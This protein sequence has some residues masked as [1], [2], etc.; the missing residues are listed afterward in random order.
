[1]KSEDGDDGVTGELPVVSP[2]DPRVTVVG[3]E[4]AAEAAAAA[5]DTDLPHWTEAPTGQVPA[6][7][8]RDAPA[9]DDPWSSIPAP[10]WREN[11][12]DWVAHDEQFDHSMLSGEVPAV[13][14][15]EEPTPVDFLTEVEETVTTP[16]AE[17]P[18]PSR[19]LRTRRP[20]SANPLAGRAARAHSS[21]DVTV[22][23][24]TGLILGFL[25]LGLFFTGTVP[26]MVLICLALAMAVAEAY[27]SL[28]SVG[29]HPATLLGIVGTVA[30]AVG[31]YNK[32]EAA[33]GLVVAV[34]LVFTALWYLTADR[35]V[36][37]LDGVGAT[38]FVFLWLGLLGSYAALLVSPVN[39]PHRHGLAFLFG[40]IL[41]TVG[42]DVGALF[43]GRSLG[44][45]KLAP[46][47][48]P[49]KTWE[50]F[51]G[52]TVVTFVLALVILPH[53]HPWTSR[54]ALIVG[55]VICVVVPIG[56]LFESMVKRTLGLKDM[57]GLL[58]GH[59]GMLDRVDGLL[60]ALPATY[61]LVHILKLG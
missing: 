32:G 45:H 36:D 56:D 8:S 18:R 2:V 53:L 15:T 61:Y 16:A 33:I 37:V 52:G 49:G 35:K 26:V 48:S 60:F 23:T 27:A 51:L 38:V 5:S 59:G 17:L 47:I 25:V 12:S 44:R 3:A 24:V 20:A 30:L 41:L 1:L 34:F 4:V 28:R 11:E 21:K 46:T 31:A 58:P 9:D 50:G 55:A 57:G 6:V 39:Y 13:T 29:V 22:A 7:L 10:A 40:A 42:N 43:T 19:P 54:G 14:S